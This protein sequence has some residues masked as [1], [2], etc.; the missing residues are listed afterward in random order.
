MAYWPMGESI[1]IRARYAGRKFRALLRALEAGAPV[2]IEDLGKVGLDRPHTDEPPDPA[3]ESLVLDRRALALF[4]RALGAESVVFVPLTVGGQKIGFL[5]ADYASPRTFS[6]AARRRLVSLAQQASVA[7]LNL[8]QLRETEARVRREQLIRRITGQ[9]QEAPDVE[10]V[11][12]TAVME[13]GRAFGTPR[14]R[15]LF[16]E[17]ETAHRG[18]STGDTDPGGGGGPSQP[19]DKRGKDTDL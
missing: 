4:R 12:K 17:P 19:D 10:G 9:I 5:H 15:I 18:I 7:V 6:D 11:L 1:Q 2:F 13:L 16:R 14:G 8:R 3:R